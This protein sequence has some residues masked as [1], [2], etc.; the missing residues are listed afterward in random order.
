DALG[1]EHGSALPCVPAAAASAT[2]APAAAAIPTAAAA[3]VPPT[4]PRQRGRL[5]LQAAAR[6]GDARGQHLALVD[7]NLHADAAEG[8]LGLVEAVVDVRA[9]RVERHPAVGVMLRAGHLGAAQ[10]A[11]ALDLHALGAGAH[12][13]GE[14][15]LHRAAEADPVLEL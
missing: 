3:T 10:A 14:R 15:A 1:H 11:G 12:G 2:V 7:P 5:G 9:Q 13:R 4:A 6:I 8:G